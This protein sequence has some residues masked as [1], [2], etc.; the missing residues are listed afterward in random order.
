MTHRAGVQALGRAGLRTGRA[1]A[2]GAEGG[3]RAWHGVPSAGL[4]LVRAASEKNVV[5]VFVVK[6]GCTM[7]RRGGGAAEVACE[8]CS[9]GGLQGKRKYKGSPLSSGQCLLWRPPIFPSEPLPSPLLH[10]RSTPDMSPCLCRGPSKRYITHAAPTAS[11]SSPPL[12]LSHAA[13]VHTCTA[14]SDLT[15]STPL[16]P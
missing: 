9:R 15:P 11:P 4:S 6:M 14:A 7:S 10:A 3:N 8:A 2:T 16:P 5:F 1:G 12:H 13:R